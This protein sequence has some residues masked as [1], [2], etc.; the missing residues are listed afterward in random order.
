MK[1]TSTFVKLVLHI[2]LELRQ[3]SKTRAFSHLVR[4][5]ADDGHPEFKHFNGFSR[6]FEA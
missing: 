3:I 6:L 2:Y 1:S 5:D 4:P